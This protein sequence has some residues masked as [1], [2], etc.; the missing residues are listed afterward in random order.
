M[1]LRI[2]ALFLLG[3]GGLFAGPN[4]VFFLADDLGY[5][6]TSATGNPYYRTPQ[7]E[8]LAA[9]GLAFN[10]AYAAAAV[11]SPTR[12][13]IM[14]GQSPARIGLTDFIAGNPRTEYPLAQPAWQQW[15]PLSHTT[16]GELFQ[17]RGYRTAHFG[18][19]H[20]S[21]GK[22]PPESLG[23]NP[24]KQGFDEHFVTY[25]PTGRTDPEDDPHQTDRITA[26]GVDF[27][28]RH[29]D[30]PFFLFLSYNAIH[31]PLVESAAAIAR[32]AADP[33]SA[34]AENH[35]VIRELVERLDR[36]LG[37]VLD[38]LDA[39]GLAEDTLVVFFSDNGGKHAYAAQ[40]PFR[41]GKGWLYEGGIRVPLVVRWPGRIAA[42]TRSE[43]PVISNDFYPTFRELLGSASTQPVDG[44]S[45]LAH[46]T[47]GVALPERAFFWHYPHYHYG[48]GM[49]PA[50]AIRLGNL[51]L[52]EWL[53]PAVLGE[54][55]ALELY[56]LSADPGETRNLAPVRPG[57]AKILRA[58]LRAWRERVG[59]RMPRPREQESP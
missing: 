37:R 41:A 42:G 4:V 50:S 12:A 16:L 27:I 31:D 47:A 38:A 11:C 45:L 19:W 48:S 20:L 28:A 9:A 18:K 44:V 32:H 36:G 17:S 55:G 10:Q 59:A 35:P 22:R 52:I 24:D 46:W 6:Q 51:K 40:A 58:R 25:K 53:E 49:K 15:L 13:S 21:P 1:V 39:H 57:V 3:A 56:D 30:R 34:Q 7:L 8:R 54:D 14:T 29:R 5:A 33:A 23:F 2:A 43:A 26:A